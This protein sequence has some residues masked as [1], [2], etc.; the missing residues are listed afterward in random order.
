M[1]LNLSLHFKG[2]VHIRAK[3]KKVNSY[4]NIYQKLFEFPWHFKKESSIFLGSAGV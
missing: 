2:D 1:D 4:K 3:M